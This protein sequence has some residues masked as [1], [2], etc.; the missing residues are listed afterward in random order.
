MITEIKMQFNTSYYIR[1]NVFSPQKIQIIDDNLFIVLEP[2]DNSIKCLI[3]LPIDISVL[4]TINDSFKSFT[5]FGYLHFFISVKI[6]KEKILNSIETGKSIK[7][8]HEL[9]YSIQK[10][11]IY[12][13]KDTLYLPESVSNYL[14]SDIFNFF[15]YQKHYISKILEIEKMIETGNNSKYL[16]RSGVFESDSIYYDTEYC[17]ITSDPDKYKTFIPFLG[18]S[19]YLPRGFGKSIIAAGVV[20]SSNFLR[21]N[22]N[23]DISRRV[24]DIKATFILTTSTKYS[25]YSKIFK[26]ANKNVLFIKSLKAYN[27]TSFLD[28][29]NRDVIII[30]ESF[31]STYHDILFNDNFISSNTST[32]VS[33]KQINFERLIIDN[34]NVKLASSISYHKVLC[35]SND[36]DNIFNTFIFDHRVDNVFAPSN[37]DIILKEIN[38]KEHKI[39]NVPY[40]LTYKEKILLSEFSKVR[41]NPNEMNFLNDPFKFATRYSINVNFKDYNDPNILKFNEIGTCPI[42]IDDI[43][44]K[45]GTRCGHIFCKDCINTW[46]DNNNHC[47][48]CRGELTKTDIFYICDEIIPDKSSKLLAIMDIIFSLK[49]DE[50]TLITYDTAFMC[51]NILQELNLAGIDYITQAARRSDIAIDIFIKNKTTNLLFIHNI[52][53]SCD[54][55]KIDNII[56]TADTSLSKI[57]LEC[58]KSIKCN[59]SK[60]IFN[61]NCV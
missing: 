1:Y 10:S 31:F 11:N 17:E 3:P 18:S 22:A 58:S 48:C 28:L 42:C 7:Y 14:V 54:L 8:I 12:K 26:L 49:A 30:S 43:S 38:N 4:D 59:T 39:I 47:P 45:I 55:E 36:K 41:K 24:L 29:Q 57:L 21:T 56:L 33:F 51:E 16:L 13:V 60:K 15:P 40:C 61:F 37:T 53:R 5:E 9:M 25:L 46:V 44:M 52:G 32:S 2:D 23:L 34:V 20:I 6:N 50:K 27:N 19:L 35:V